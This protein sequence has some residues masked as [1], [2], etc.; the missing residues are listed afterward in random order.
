MVMSSIGRIRM[1]RPSPPP[2][3]TDDVRVVMIGTAAWAVGFLALLPFW[4]RLA[5]AGRL[6]W[7]GA[8]A[9]GFGLGLVGLAYVRRRAA[10]IARDEAAARDQAGPD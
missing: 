6:W 1:T 2:R 4:G 10:A 5:D 8:C 9:F 3:R 7:L